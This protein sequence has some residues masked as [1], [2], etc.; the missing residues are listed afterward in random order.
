MQNVSIATGLGRLQLTA[1]QYYRT[2]LDDKTDE[3][4][5]LKVLRSGSNVTMQ[6]AGSIVDCS[7]AFGRQ[8]E[9]TA[10]ST[11]AR[12]FNRQYCVVGGVHVEF[13]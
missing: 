6:L 8:I 9:Y 2:F 10:N 12:P 4:S 3:T 13:V 5:I 7:N 11:Q 1:G